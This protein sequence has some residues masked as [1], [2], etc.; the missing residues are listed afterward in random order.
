MA[1]TVP[2][3]GTRGTRYPKFPGRLARF[4]SRLQVRTFRRNK[5]GRSQGGVPTFILETIGARS[6]ETRHAMLGYIDEAAGSWLVVASLAGSARNP[7]SL[8]NLARRP[9]ATIEFADGRR[10]RVS[11]LSLAGPELDAAWKRFS[12]EAPEYAGYLSATDRAMPI[13][14]LRE[15]GAD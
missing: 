13:V 2:P 8:Y 11:A 6:G 5:G 14:R 7:S 10:V 9:E 12:R 15:L 3:A 1:V 4:F